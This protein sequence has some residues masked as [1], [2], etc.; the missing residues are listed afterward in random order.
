[1]MYL[2]RLNYSAIKKV[3]KMSSTVGNYNVNASM[4]MIQYY[5][6]ILAEVILHNEYL[7]FC[8]IC[9]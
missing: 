8:Y 6:N 1:M 7:Y 4:I 2:F 3:I 9:C 5:N